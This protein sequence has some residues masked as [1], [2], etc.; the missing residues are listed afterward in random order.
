MLIRPRTR[1]LLL[2]LALALGCKTGESTPPAG[3]DPSGILAEG[4]DEAGGEGEVLDA[5][6][7]PGGGVDPAIEQDPAQPRERE[8]PPA[9]KTRDAALVAVAHGNP[10]GAVAFLS[11][12][13]DGKASDAEAMLALAR[14]QRLIGDLEAAEKTLSKLHKAAKDKADKAEALRRRAHLHFARGDMKQAEADIRAARKLAPDDILLRGELVRLM[15]LS[16]RAQERE[17]RE[18]IDELY[19]SYSDGTAQSAPDLLGTAYAG[20]A[21]RAFKSTSRVLQEA[22]QAAPPAEGSAI[23]DEVSMELTDLFLEKYKPGEAA[24]TLALVLERDPWHPEALAKMGWVYLDQFQL[25]AASRTA[26]EA[27]QVNPENADAHAVLAWVAMIEGDRELARAHIIDHVV[28]VNPSHHG[29]QIV[30]AALAIFDRNEAAYAKARDAVLAF[31]P[32]DGRFF[33]QLS[34]LLGYLHL[35]PESDT[36]LDEGVKILPND[37]YV[38]GALGLSKLRLGDEAGGRAALDK[39]WRKDKYNARTLNV[40]QLYSE[41]IEPH[42]AERKE[43]DLTLRLPAELQD[44]LAPG[45]I[46]AITAARRALDK[47]YGIKISPLRIEMYAEPDEFSIRTVGVPSLGALGVCFGQVITSLGPYMGTHN[48]NQV[49]WHEIAHSYAIELSDGRVPRWFTEGLSEWESELAD[50]SWAR[51]SAALLYE[52]R[53]HDKLRKLSELELAFLRAENPLMMEVAYAT[54]AWAMRYLGETYGRPKII[55]LLKGY[56]TGKSTDELFRQIL[57]KDLATV[58]K[59]F[60]AWFDAELDRKLTGWRPNQEQ[61]DDPRLKALMQAFEVA[62][63]GD[64]DQAQ[65]LL[66][67]LIASKGD[68]FQSRMTLATVLEKKGEYKQAIKHYEKAASFALE[69]VEPFV[70][71]AKVAR[72]QKDV[73]LELDQLEKILA[74]DAMSLDPVLRMIVMAAAVGDPRLELAVERANAIAP[75]HPSALAGSVILAARKKANKKRID[76]M[77]DEIMVTALRPDATLDVVVMAALAAE[78]V[79][80]PRVKDLAPRALQS[81]E[82]PEPARKKL[83]KHAP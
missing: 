42:Y 22:E 9:P 21:E 74:I 39:A 51:E 48:F 72:E 76:A 35:Y 31:N 49:I 79:G 59:E 71:I 16:G 75:L 47:G 58:E 13:L 26:K 65:G 18:L 17:A 34:D 50:P 4:N 11:K 6:A 53:R 60:S 82:L 29:G 78:A 27:L 52:A 41:R 30:L 5:S 62:G 15:F 25:A 28:N 43:R 38:L 63:K 55:E 8:L 80:D 40:R 69:S 70:G 2:L 83:K 57:G 7:I 32:R 73:Q 36:V 12:H 66:E 14:A 1:H 61:Q 19:A 54:A 20:L 67:K 44:L 10:E 23:A 33:S 56:A 3:G 68:G 46:S 37:P 24:Q 77:L 81:Q 45:Y 64:L